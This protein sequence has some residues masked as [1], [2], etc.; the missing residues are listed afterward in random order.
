M[1]NADNLK[2]GEPEHHHHAEALIAYAIGELAGKF[3]SVRF[4]V[5]NVTDDDITSAPGMAEAARLDGLGSLAR[6]IE[7]DGMEADSES[8]IA[9][10]VMAFMYSDAMRDVNQATD[11][12][13]RRAS[14]LKGT[15]TDDTGTIE[16]GTSRALDRVLGHNPQHEDALQ[17][18]RAVGYKFT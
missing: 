6:D 5:V 13:T 16:S 2:W 17:Y 3:P 8:A 7:R 9:T 18:M 11:L 14:Q 1:A 15:I 10:Q 4:D 12:L